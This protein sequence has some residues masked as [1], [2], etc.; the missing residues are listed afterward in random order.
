MG[1]R[2]M[3]KENRNMDFSGDVFAGYSILKGNDF[4]FN[5]DKFVIEMDSVKYFELF[6]ITEKM[7][8][9]G[10]PQA[11]SI[12]SRIENTTGTLMIDAPGNKSGKENIEFFPAFKSRG[13]AYVYYDRDSTHKGAY[14]RDS[15]YFEI[16]PFTFKNL[17]NM[18][19]SDL[20]FKGRLVS[21]GILPDIE[22]TLIL[23]EEDKSLGFN[24]ETD[25]SGLGV[26]QGQGNYTGNIDLS[27]QG[28]QGEGNL[29]YLG[30]NTD[31]EDILFKP[32]EMTATAEQFDLE[33][34]RE[35]GKEFPQ[36][37]GKDV[38]INWKPYQDSM[39]VESQENAFNLYKEENYALDGTLI[40]TP[41]DLRG[42]GDFDWEEGHLKSD[43]FSFGAFSITSDSAAMKVKAADNPE[44]AAVSNN[45]VNVQIDFE[46]RQGRFTANKEDVPTQLPYNSYQTTMNNFD[47]DMDEKLITFESNPDEPAVFQ[48]NHREQDSLRFEG[49]SA[50]YNLSSSALKI[51]GV[52]YIHSCDAFIFPSDGNVE[53]NPGGAI[54]TLENARIV[55]DTINRYHIINRATVE[56]KGKKH[57][58]AEGYY[59]Y[60]IESREQEIRF[61]NVIG[62]RVGKGRSQ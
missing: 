60:N 41:N 26:Y 10:K 48:S 2:L 59:E 15:F 51:G 34:S 57:Y 56:V 1:G 14:T 37:S 33:E 29:K 54:T 5:Y 40:L 39:Y 16:E 47:W 52:P 3:L 12:G 19:A 62:Q 17:D 6:P 53:V 13:N 50:S 25:E 45:D 55:A 4:H 36:A 44:E 22:E 46:Q 18:T 32:K 49:E 58:T 31:S 30:A 61:D 35:G 9:R 20:E 24:T 38:A 21:G 8:K 42:Q 23:R 43:M 11:F 27:N 28:L 7:D